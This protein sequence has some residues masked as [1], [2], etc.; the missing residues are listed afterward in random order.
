V[1]DLYEE[2]MDRYRIEL[3]ALQERHRGLIIRSA[4]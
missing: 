1:F 2:A 4:T 3:K